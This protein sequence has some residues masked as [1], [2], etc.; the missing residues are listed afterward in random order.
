MKGRI[1]FQLG[2]RCLMTLAA[3]AHVEVPA[4]AQPASRP[5][6]E[7]LEAAEA[8][9]EV[10]PEQR[11][12]VASQAVRSA[13]PE[14]AEAA[15]GFRSADFHAAARAAVRAEVVRELSQPQRSRGPQVAARSPTGDASHGAAADARDSA[16]QAQQARLNHSVIAGGATDHREAAPPPRR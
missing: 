9:A 6:L 5:I 10:E 2:L 11:P 12:A 7:L 3:V 14:H 15:A 13:G 4:Q 8:T 16:L 1:T